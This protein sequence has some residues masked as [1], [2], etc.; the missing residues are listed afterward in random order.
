MKWLPLAPLGSFFSRKG[1]PWP[2]H[3]PGLFPVTGRDSPRQEMPRSWPRI[4]PLSGRFQ[5]VFD[6][7]ESRSSSTIF[8]QKAGSWK[9]R[10]SNLQEMQRC[11]ETR[12]GGLSHQGQGANWWLA[13][14]SLWPW[15]E[16]RA[17]RKQKGHRDAETC[18][19]QMERFS[20]S[21]SWLQW[22]CGA[23]KLNRKEKLVPVDG[24]EWAA[25]FSF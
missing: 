6:L 12:P 3:C 13:G 10:L 15:G 8:D 24:N 21:F 22:E 25:S 17:C 11:C 18:R 4:H 2:M 20:A 16:K 5:P 1:T 14:L 9:W 19:L 23:S 7:L